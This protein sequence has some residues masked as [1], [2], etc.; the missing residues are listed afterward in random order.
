MA[1]KPKPKGK[2]KGKKPGGK[3]WLIVLAITAFWAAVNE[4]ADFTIGAAMVWGL[5]AVSVAFLVMAGLALLGP[6]VVLAIRALPRPK[7]GGGEAD[8]T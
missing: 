7:P 6:A 1:S 2:G 5:T 4:P 8:E 3:R